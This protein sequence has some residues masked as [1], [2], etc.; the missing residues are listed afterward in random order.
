MVEHIPE[1]PN[2]GHVWVPADKVI[3]WPYCSV[4]L[5][6]KRANGTN[7]PCKGPGRLRQPESP[8]FSPNFD[9]RNGIK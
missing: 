9:E 1:D 4:C 8:S 7:K 3:S 2:D 5:I 6:I